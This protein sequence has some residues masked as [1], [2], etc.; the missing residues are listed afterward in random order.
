MPHLTKPNGYKNTKT[1]E[2][3][4]P[5]EMKPLNKPRK[6]LTKLQVE[7]MKEHSKKHSPEHNKEMRRLM[8]LGWCVE[9]SHRLAMKNVGK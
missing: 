1:S 3:K 9:Q 6:Q 8:K 5:S 2:M 7:F 4:K